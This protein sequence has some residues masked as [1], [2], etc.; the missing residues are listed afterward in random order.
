MKIVMEFR[1]IQWATKGVNNCLSTKFTSAS[2][3]IIGA[4]QSPQD[5][6]LIINWFPPSIVI[7][8][9]GPHHHL[10]L[11]TSS[12]WVG[13]SRS[14]RFLPCSR[15]SWRGNILWILEEFQPYLHI[16]TFGVW[17]GFLSF[18]SVPFDN[19]HSGYFLCL[20]LQ[21][22]WQNIFRDAL[23]TFLR[24]GEVRHFGKIP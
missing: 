24:K 16:S 14:T 3:T 17:N 9:I 20:E 8:I 22:T 7:L 4:Y 15:A 12:C 18:K 2:A 10:S 6:L 23:I 5:V 19:V 21:Q 11:G 1:D 13:T